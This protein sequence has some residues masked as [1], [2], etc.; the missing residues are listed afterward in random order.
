[1]AYIKATNTVLFN[2]I[3]SN[4]EKLRKATDPDGISRVRDITYIVGGDIVKT[5][6]AELTLVTLN[7]NKTKLQGTPLSVACKGWVWDDKLKEFISKTS[8]LRGECHANTL[9][10]SKGNKLVLKWVTEK[11]ANGTYMYQDIEYPLKKVEFRPE[12]RGILV[13][14]FWHDGVFFFATGQRLRMVDL[15]VTPTNN[16]EYNTDTYML[17][18]FQASGIRADDLFDI[19]KPYS[20]VT[21][22]FLYSDPLYSKATYEDTTVPKVTYMGATISYNPNILLSGLDNGTIL[23]GLCDTI[24]REPKNVARWEPIDF[25][26]ANQM[27]VSGY[28][29]G[30][31]YEWNLSGG[32]SIMVNTPDG[33]YHVQ[34][35]A[36][37]WRESYSEIMLDS[38]ESRYFKALARSPDFMFPIGTLNAIMP[39]IREGKL[40]YVKP[41]DLSRRRQGKTVECPSD[42][43]ESRIICFALSC[44]PVEQRKLED[45]IEQFKKEL[46]IVMDYIIETANDIVVGGKGAREIPVLPTHQGGVKLRAFIESLYA[47]IDA[48]RGELPLTEFVE[49]EIVRLAD[50]PSFVHKF[51]TAITPKY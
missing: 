13:R 6:N 26:A 8:V 48:Y 40:R 45:I 15:T 31:G 5:S 27:L 47:Q 29:D 49:A 7:P 41:C 44:T 17:K 9:F 1:M 50:Y 32:E 37:F 34:C 25:A 16:V 36:A 21:Y 3:V 51:Y 24:I 19:S 22:S 12:H 4:C 42:S 18:F 30:S 20:N 43:D 46:T 2:S 33:A 14:L 38:L 39:T 23:E 11:K 10:V 28:T 35:D